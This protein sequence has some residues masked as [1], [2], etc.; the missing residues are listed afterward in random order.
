MG[1]TAVTNA[2]DGPDQ[3]LWPIL[4]ASLQTVKWMYRCCTAASDGFQCWRRSKN[5]PRAQA[6]EVMN[7][8]FTP[9]WNVYLILIIFI[10][11]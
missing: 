9:A 5:E 1:R 10:D 2:T 4:N 6:R 11:A 7:T 3:N 8:T